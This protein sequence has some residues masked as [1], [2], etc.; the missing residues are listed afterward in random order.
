MN[1]KVLISIIKTKVD[2][3]AFI[4]LLYK[5]MKVGYGENLKSVTPMKIVLIQGGILLP[6]LV[7]I[8]MNPFDEWIENHLMSIFNLRDKRKKNLEY[9]KKYYQDG[10]K[11]KDKSINGYYLKIPAIGKCIILNM[12][13]ILLLV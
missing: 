4:D 5:Y 11:V 2:G 3:Q 9:F 1:H 12:R 8:Y 6:I 7:N 13:M 10:L